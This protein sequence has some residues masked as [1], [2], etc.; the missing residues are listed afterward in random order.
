M[1][2]TTP[3]IL[4]ARVFESDGVTPVPGKG[5]LVAG[6][7]YSL[8]YNGS[9]CELMFTA[10]SNAAVIGIDERLMITYRAQLDTN[11]QD[12][13]LLTNVAGAIAWE[14][15]DGSTQY[16]RTLTDGTV[17]AGDHEDA[18]TVLAELPVL[19]FEKTVVNVTTGQ[20]P[21]TN[22]AQLDTLRYRLY[23]EN[24]S[25][26]P[27]D[28]FSVVDE[29]DVLNAGASFVPG[30]LNVV[31][32]PAGAADN[33]DPNGGAAGTGLLDI[34]NLSIGG[35]GD[36]VVVEFEVQ[37]ASTIP[38]GTYVYN[39]SDLMFGD[40]TAAISDDPNL[41]GDDDPTRVLVE[42]RPP[43]ALGKAITRDTVTIGENYNY[44]ITVP[45]IPYTEPLY[46]VRIFDDLSA[47]AADLRYVTITNISATIGGV[48]ENTGDSTSLVLED[49]TSG[50]DIPAGEQLVLRL[51]V[52]LLNTPTNVAGLTYTNT[53][54]YTYNE[55]DDDPAT[56]QVGDPGT[57][58]PMTDSRAGSRHDQERSID[59]RDWCSEDVYTGCAQCWRVTGLRRYLDGP[60]AQRR[61]TAV[62]VMCRHRTSRRRCLRL[63]ARRL[64]RRCSRREPTL[65]RALPAIRPAR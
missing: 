54:Y 32:L 62:C 30:T 25:D 61:R 39:Q 44:V 26:V 46:D 51:R 33:S 34:D 19:D 18:H 65:R 8:N 28:D 31:S 22:A 45:S 56:Q 58:A 20:D 42:A 53:A 1:C 2:D 36:T 13:E 15:E 17:S 4:S 41:P 12:G 37:L 59:R 43:A 48:A 7:D 47:S 5:A 35:L 63:M 11:T 29:L 9:A 14:T 64:F 24:L 16:R 3:E 50:F 52:S 57:S 40:Y 6:P 60:P 23:V 55:V 21:G 27:V 38:S 10:L 49:L